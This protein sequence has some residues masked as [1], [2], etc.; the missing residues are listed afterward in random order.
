MREVLYFV[1]IA[2]LSVSAAVGDIE[3]LN[4][5]FELMYDP[6]D[7]EVFHRPMYWGSE[8]FAA[9]DS[10]FTAVPEHGQSPD[11]YFE[12]ET[13][14]PFEGENCLVLSTDDI[15]PDGGERHASVVQ[16]YNFV[17]G[18]TIEFYY[19]FGTFD[20]VPYGDF[21]TVTLL[22]DRPVEIFSIAVDDIGNYN[23]TDGWVK[24]EKF[25]DPC[26]LDPLHYEYS[27]IEFKVEDATD[28]IYK[29]YFAVDAM[30]IGFKPEKGDFNDDWRV[31]FEDFAVFAQDWQMV[32]SNIMDP[33]VDIDDNNYVDVNDMMNFCEHWLDG[34]ENP[35]YWP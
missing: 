25:L 9:T 4:A 17:E 27:G 26:D 33:N 35:E 21:A 15:G 23:S 10:N 1:I 3:L 29:T 11:W 34:S 19:F 22:N 20:Y 8:N 24:F 2:A 31:N 6:C 30:R 32:D 28:L 14:I 18:L 16:D 13:I 12:E 5:N 7:G